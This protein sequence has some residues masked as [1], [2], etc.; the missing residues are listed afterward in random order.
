M[1]V[2]DSETEEATEMMMREDFPDTVFFPF[3]KNVGFQALCT[4]LG[5]L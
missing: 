3:E 2:A 5:L 1:V 4:L